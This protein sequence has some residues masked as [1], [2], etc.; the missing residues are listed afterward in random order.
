MKIFTKEECQK[1]AVQELS[2]TTNG[3]KLET[4]SALSFRAICLAKEGSSSK[5]KEN[6]SSI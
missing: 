6:M 3:N 1:I 5:A 4:R 2:A